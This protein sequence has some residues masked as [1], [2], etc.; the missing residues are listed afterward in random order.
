MHVKMMSRTKPRVLTKP[1][2]LEDPEHKASRKRWRTANS[3]VGEYESCMYEP[4]S[5]SK[6]FVG[7]LGVHPGGGSIELPW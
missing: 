5:F 1:H 7:R 4:P 3:D 6:F 2:A